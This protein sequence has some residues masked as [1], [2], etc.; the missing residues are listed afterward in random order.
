MKLSLRQL[1][2]T[3]AAAFLM[4][5]LAAPA[6]LAAYPPGPF[7]GP[8]PAGT[9]PTVLTSQTVCSEGGSLVVSTGAA[10]IRLD[11]PPAAFPDCAQIT[12]YGADEA[13]VSPLVPE[14]Y[15][16][17]AA[18][19]IAWTPAGPPA[20][21]LPLTVSDTAITTY[22]LAFR[23]TG[24]GITNDAGL[25][26]DTGQVA[27]SV[28]EPLGIVIASPGVPN[29]STGEAPGTGPDGGSPDGWPL[30]MLILAIAGVAGLGALLL[31]SGHHQQMR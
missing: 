18:L 4:L 10:D 30:V 25:L 6:V 24:G 8:A 2:A 28:T 1:A 16:F 15:V 20:S 3:A 19:A 14:H 13:L 21:G 11:V 7:P 22:S 26:V 5:C 23:T 12:I 29:T 27:T 9:F 31:L 17:V